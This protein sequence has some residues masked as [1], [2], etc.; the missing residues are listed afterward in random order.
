M[1]K[2]TSAIAEALRLIPGIQETRWYQTY[3]K[4]ADGSYSATPE[5]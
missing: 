1:R 2:V 4:D 5:Y 3:G